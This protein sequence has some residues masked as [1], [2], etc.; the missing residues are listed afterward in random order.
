MYDD[1]S[2]ESSDASLS[3]SS[4]C[5]SNIPWKQKSNYCHTE[6][7]K[8][9]PKLVIQMIWQGI[10]FIYSYKKNSLCFQNTKNI[11]WYKIFFSVGVLH[12]DSIFE[13]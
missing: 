10:I 2:E 6:R 3:S 7:R 8:S 4:E 9:T 12:F 1:S 13:K 11:S 5:L